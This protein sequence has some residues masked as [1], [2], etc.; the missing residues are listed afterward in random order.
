M[1]DTLGVAGDWNSDPEK[2]LT[3]I[4]ESVKI[5][6]LVEALERRKGSAKVVPRANDSS[7][8]IEGADREGG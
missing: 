7:R 4:I 6:R 3:V 8:E 5:S 2:V 1:E